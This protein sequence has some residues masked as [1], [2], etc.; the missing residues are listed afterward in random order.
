MMEILFIQFKYSLT[1]KKNFKFFLGV[2]FILFIY[3]MKLKYYFYQYDLK[4]SLVDYV[5]FS[6]GGW[7]N[8][9]L[10]TFLLDWIFFVFLVLCICIIISNEFEQLNIF[11]LNRIGSKS[12][13]W[14]YICINQV[15]I[16][17][18]VTLF[19]FVVT[20]GIGICFLGFDINT[21]EYTKFFYNSL[22]D[23]NFFM[24]LIYVFL[25]FFTGICALQILIKALSCIFYN[26][27]IFYIFFLLVCVFTSFLFIY[28]KLPKVLSPIFLC[29]IIESNFIS[30]Y[31]N[32]VVNVIVIF[33][34]FLIGTITCQKK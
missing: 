10:L 4:G 34:F 8:P 16:S 3:L 14:F 18:V 26:E 13:L 12:K 11:I 17:F 27:H 9:I 22:N 24:L 28:F 31:K 6:M 25:T 19:V 29:S 15:V 32:L 33:I 30:M 5:I 21:S 1:K 23:I 2:L 7:E 20:L